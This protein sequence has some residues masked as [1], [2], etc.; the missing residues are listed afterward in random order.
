MKEYLQALRNPAMMPTALQVAFIV[1]TL[2]FSINH[3]DALLK[4]KMTRA[5]WFSG[6]LTYTVPYCVNIHGQVTS[7][8]KHRQQLQRLETYHEESQEAIAERV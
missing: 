2:L 8:R 6:L 3:G 5:R 4:G 7:Q 1:G